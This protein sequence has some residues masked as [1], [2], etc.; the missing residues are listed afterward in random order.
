[1]VG[2][3]GHSNMNPYV[4]V[5]TKAQK[6]QTTPKNLEQVYLW[7]YLPGTENSQTTNANTPT[8]DPFA[9]LDRRP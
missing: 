6:P 5:L 2:G 7:Q 1:M 3:S 8:V 9:G 4:S